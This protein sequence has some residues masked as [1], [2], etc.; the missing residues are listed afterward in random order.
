LADARRRAAAGAR[1]GGEGRDNATTGLHMLRTLIKVV[2]INS[3]K[4]FTGP[5]ATPS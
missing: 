2:V 4:V 1:E 5:W 3:N